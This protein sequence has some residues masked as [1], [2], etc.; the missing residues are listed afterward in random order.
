MK[1][2]QYGM[3]GKEVKLGVVERIMDHEGLVGEG[4]WDQ[5][6]GMQEMKQE[7]E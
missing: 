6:G 3:E 5:E 4:E 2:E 1:F 7:K